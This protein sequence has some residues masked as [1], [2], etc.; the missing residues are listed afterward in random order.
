MTDLTRRTFLAG[1]GL[2]AAGTLLAGAPGMARASTAPKIATV[3]TNGR[4]WTG[5]GPDAQAIAIDAR[6]GIAAVGSNREISRLAGSGTETVDAGG[7]TVIAGIHDGHVHPTAVVQYLIYPTLDDAQLT[8]AEMQAQ[9]QAFLDDPATVFPGGWLVVLGWN[10]VACPVDALP[11]NKSYLDVLTTDRP[12]ILRGSDGHNS[13]VNSK[14]LELAGISAST[15]N[16]PG[17]QIVH[18]ANGQPSGV[19]VDNAQ[20]LVMSLIPE[21]TTEEQ[22]PYMQQISWFM[23]SKGITSF[24]DAWVSEESLQLYSALSASGGLLQRGQTALLVPQSLFDKPKQA[25]AWARG[26]AQQYTATT[27]MRIRTVKIFLDGVMEY[28]AQT[29]SLL[30]PYLDGDGQ[31]TDNYGSLYV[32]NP[33]LAK[34]VTEFDRAGWQVHFHAIGDRAVRTGLDAFAAARKANGV[35]NGRHTIAHLQLIDPADYSRFAKLGVVPVWQLQWAC[36]DYWTGPALQPYIGD[37]RHARLYPAHSVQV[38]GS[39]MAGGSDWPVDP[40]SPWNQVATA[41]DRIG[42]GGLPESG[43]G[44]TGQPLDPDQ[45]LSLST[46][47]RL[48]TAGSAYQLHQDK[49]TGTL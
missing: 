36:D 39:R 35:T 41:V 8:L 22:L 10:P 48:H 37:A 21:P 43:A 40:L 23:A 15:P 19:L 2:A 26:L 18:E 49:T 16:P 27:G 12:I 46:S 38:T 32:D 24:L 33:T 30:Q 11:A 20:G 17:G 4:V 31:P 29:A 13:F 9:L 42:M 25:L 1:S 5:C 47:L 34:L 44:G 3:V 6:G 28:P 7:N 45:A 14:A